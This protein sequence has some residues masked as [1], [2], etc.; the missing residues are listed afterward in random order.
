MRATN[1]IVTLPFYDVLPS[2]EIYTSL[3]KAFVGNIIVPAKYFRP[4]DSLSRA[5]AITLLIRTSG[6]QLDSGK[7]S[8]FGDV[9]SNNTHMV[10]LN[11][12]AKYLGIK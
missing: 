8:V 1:S 12:F 3:E 7:Q 4:N 5:E 11:T 6:I 10:Y 2:D 9:K